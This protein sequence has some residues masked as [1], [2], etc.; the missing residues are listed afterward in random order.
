MFLQKYYISTVSVNLTFIVQTL[1]IWR[2]G[3]DVAMSK[4]DSIKISH[5]LTLTHGYP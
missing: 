4:K 5:L 3:D 2:L 1:L